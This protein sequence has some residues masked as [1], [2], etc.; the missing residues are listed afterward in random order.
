MAAESKTTVD[1]EE[2]KKWAEGRGGVP[3]TVK[4]TEAKGEEAGILRIHF[5]DYSS[6]EALE[7]ISWE[8][9]F[10]KFEDSKVAFLYQEETEEGKPSRFFKF[11]RREGK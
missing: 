9:F 2:I 5:P 7:E 4:G 8:D 10:E 6:E 1:H 11:V 3:A